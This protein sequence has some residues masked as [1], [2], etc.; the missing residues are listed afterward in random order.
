[1]LEKMKSYLRKND[2]TNLVREL[3]DD[4]WNSEAA[5]EYVYDGHALSKEEFVCKYFGES[6]RA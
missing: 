1:M 6:A 5:I 4:G 3:T 2:L